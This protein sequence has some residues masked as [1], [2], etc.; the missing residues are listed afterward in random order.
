MRQ[1]GVH[2]LSE[3]PVPVKVERAANEESP[4]WVYSEADE[5]KSR[6]EREHGGEQIV[7]CCMRE[8]PEDTSHQRE[9]CDVQPIEVQREPW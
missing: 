7:D 3:E 2:S 5:C 6:T 8:L 4:G 1:P 9:C